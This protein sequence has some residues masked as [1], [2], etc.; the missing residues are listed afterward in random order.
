MLALKQICDP[1]EL[2]LKFRVR[3]KN[4]EAVGR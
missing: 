1:R 3:A 2:R 4:L